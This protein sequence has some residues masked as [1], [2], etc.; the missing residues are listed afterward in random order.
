MPQGFGWSDPSEA[1]F[2]QDGPNPWGSLDL[3]GPGVA[4]AVARWQLDSLAGL[5]HSGPILLAGRDAGELLVALHMAGHEVI[6]W[7]ES[8]SELEALQQSWLLAG[9]PLGELHVVE[10][11]SGH[12]PAPA[13]SIAAVVH[14]DLR[15]LAGI[16]PDQLERRLGQWRQALRA[17]GMLWLRWAGGRSLTGACR[18][19]SADASAGGSEARCGHGMLEALGRHGFSIQGL[20]RF[21]VFPMGPADSDAPPDRTAPWSTWRH[22]LDEVLAGGKRRSTGETLPRDGRIGKG[23]AGLFAHEWI[24][25]AAPSAAPALANGFG[26]EPSASSL[27]GDPLIPTPHAGGGLPQGWKW[28]AAPGEAGRRRQRAAAMDRVIR[29]DLAGG[30]DLLV[31][32]LVADPKDLGTVVA[33]LSCCPDPGAS[34]FV[35]RCERLLDRADPTTGQALARRCQTQEAPV[36]VRQAR[37]SAEIALVVP[38]PSLEVCRNGHLGRTLESLQNQDLD[39]V[40]L[41]VMCTEDSFDTAQKAL[42]GVC[43]SRTRL[44][45]ECMANPKGP[46]PSMEDLVAGGMARSQDSTFHGWFLPGDMLGPQALPQLRRALGNHPEAAWAVGGAAT[47]V[48]A[49]LRGCLLRDPSP[50]VFLYRREMADQVGGLDPSLGQFM[51]WDL[52]LRLALQWPA[53]HVPDATC[54]A[55][56]TGPK[57]RRDPRAAEAMLQ[58]AWQRL[59]GPPPL[60]LL[61]PALIRLQDDRAEADAALHFASQMLTCP[62]W[63]T[64]SACTYLERALDLVPDHVHASL[65]L[66][67][68]RA[69]QGDAVAALDL[70][71]RVAHVPHTG[72]ARIVGDL[73]RAAAGELDPAQIPLLA[74]DRQQV[75]AL[76]A[77]TPRIWPPEEDAGM[78][79]STTAEAGVAQVSTIVAAGT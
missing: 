6:P 8:G 71:Q 26:Q 70:T 42:R 25:T 37:R 15:P 53:I 62:W 55:S 48:D 47:S 49:S 21:G 58:R 63:P 4:A 51:G 14:T 16:A 76:R 31:E 67:I 3:E 24:C 61:Y 44:E 28:R 30:L 5:P 60:E 65:H 11:G 57:G 27:Q 64:S 9:L 23:P 52:W 19:G 32:M 38:V 56:G 50:T 13:E 59:G 69:R 2:P 34:D 41:R 45:I 43:G 74:V 77:E 40:R 10:S 79:S 54:S 18:G 7:V 46:H 29:G 72:I 35:A 20:E 75:A 39:N 33:L 78:T 17:D 36:G 73:V 68:G 1:L 66:A 22:A 12:P